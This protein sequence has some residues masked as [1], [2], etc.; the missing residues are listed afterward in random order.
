VPLSYRWPPASEAASPPRFRA[1]PS[2]FAA[3]TD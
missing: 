1:A 2:C 3:F